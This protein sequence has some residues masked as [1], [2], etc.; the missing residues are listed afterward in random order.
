MKHLLLAPLLLGFISPVFAEVD[1]KAWLKTK[2][3]TSEWL[4]TK[5]WDNNQWWIDSLAIF[6]NRPTK[7]INEKM[8]NE[9]KIKTCK[10]FIQLNDYTSELK[11]SCKAIYQKLSIRAKKKLSEEEKAFY[12]G[13]KWEDDGLS[14]MRE[15]MEEKDFQLFIE[16]RNTQYKVKKGWFNDQFHKDWRY[17]LSGNPAVKNMSKRDL[18]IERLHMCNLYATERG[19]NFPTLGIY[20]NCLELV[21]KFK[22][23]NQTSNKKEE[24]NTTQPSIQNS[25]NKKN[26]DKCLNAADY[27]GCM[28]YQKK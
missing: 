11:D 12:E 10:D 20:I 3:S 5:N 16:V 14:L 23:I 6:Y 4:E 24:S 2:G 17:E 28:R 18:L 27:A 1:E 8:I 15:E 19:L 9:A 26:H 25:D 22:K 21:E 13:R 7:R